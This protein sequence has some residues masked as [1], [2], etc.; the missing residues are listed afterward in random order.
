MNWTKLCNLSAI[1]LATLYSGQSVNAMDHSAE[2]GTNFWATYFIDVKDNY[3]VTL[4][5]LV[6]AVGDSSK[7]FATVVPGDHFP[8]NL[9]DSVQLP[10]C[11]MEHLHLCSPAC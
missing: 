8:F 1:F 6:E 10:S 9:E 2:F 3:T 11:H 5:S 7:P 4:I